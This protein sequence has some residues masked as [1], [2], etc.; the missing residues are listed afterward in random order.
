MKNRVDDPGPC[1]TRVKKL[2]SGP[3]FPRDHGGGGAAG[4]D[5]DRCVFVPEMPFSPGRLNCVKQKTRHQTSRAGSGARSGQ[6]V[7]VQGCFRRKGRGAVLQPRS[8]F[9][10]PPIPTGNNEKNMTIDQ[11]T[12]LAYVLRPVVSRVLNDPPNVREEAR[13][14]VLEVIEE[15]D[16]RP[17]SVACSLAT[18]RSFEISALTPRRG[19][20]LQAYSSFSC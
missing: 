9:S 6:Q 10:Q 14:R 3:A 13:Q 7:V 1:C 11:V 19:D 2:H 15:H 12:K 17:S 8:F 5:R 4:P 18:D 20:E 16:Y